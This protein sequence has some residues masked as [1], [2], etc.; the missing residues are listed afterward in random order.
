VLVF[1]PMRTM[2]FLCAFPSQGAWTC[3][4]SCFGV[5]DYETERDKEFRS[6]VCVAHFRERRVK[7]GSAEGVEMEAERS[8]RLPMKVNHA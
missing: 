7:D 5:L 2:I 4:V 8:D 3:T 6:H 1:C